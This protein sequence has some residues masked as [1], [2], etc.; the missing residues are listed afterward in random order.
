MNAR[1]EMDEDDYF[2]HTRMSLGDHIEELRTA[3]W[4]AIKGFFLCLFIGFFFAKAA[5]N[6]I[7]YPVRTELE[8]FHDRR[9]AEQKEKLKNG[10]EKLE[11]ANAPRP[12]VFTVDKAELMRA[13]D[14]DPGKVPAGATVKLTLGVPPF[15]VVDATHKAR[16]LYDPEDMI[17]GMSV[18]E[19]FIVWMKV[20]VA[21]GFILAGPWIFLQIWLFVAA[22]LYPH[23]KKYVH[24]Y[25]PLSIALF[26]GGAA[27]CQFVA[28]PLGVRWLL[29][30]N[31]WLSIEPELRLSEWLGFAILMPVL[32]GLAFQTPMVMLF[33]E[34][35]G[36][37]TVDTYR[38]HRRIAIFVICIFATIFAVAPDPFS[39][40]ILAVPMC[41]LYEVGIL[42][43]RLSP[44]PA[45][46]LGE[47]DADEMVE[48]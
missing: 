14:L 23:E 13:V 15:D 6:F 36:M 19:A 40:A 21:I 46:E 7:T 48:V 10:D 1:P 39:M 5:L 20:A 32:F 11:E 16:K 29:D 42:L 26:L 45:P 47:V 28:L 44:R 8:A 17:K 25:L 38:N 34:R 9:I 27:L 2:A 24:F 37:C 18:V 43:C 30:F 22:G 3:L 33:L 4:R 12:V 41:L 35:V 31:R